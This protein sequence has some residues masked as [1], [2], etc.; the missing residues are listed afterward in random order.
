MN[1]AHPVFEFSTSNFQRCARQTEPRLVLLY[2]ADV[3][4][5]WR[6]RWCQRG[7]RGLRWWNCRWC[8]GREV[9]RGRLIVGGIIGR[10]EVVHG[11]GRCP[12]IET[13]H[14]CQGGNKRCSA[15]RRRTGLL[16]ALIDAITREVC[17]SARIPCQCHTPGCAGPQ[18]KDTG[19]CSDPGHRNAPMCFL[20]RKDSCFEETNVSC[21]CG[22]VGLFDC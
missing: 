15:R 4:P 6:R 18:D 14:R 12:D 17:I 2:S 21:S 16:T 9:A 5:P 8:E 11:R 20:R 19:D 10:N 22:H 7:W 3:Q 1:D 13:R